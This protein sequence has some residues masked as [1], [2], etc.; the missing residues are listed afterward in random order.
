MYIDVPRPL[1]SD[2]WVFLFQKTDAGCVELTRRSGTSVFVKAFRV[3]VNKY[4]KHFFLEQH[5]TT[6]NTV[7]LQGFLLVCNLACIFRFV[8]ACNIFRIVSVSRDL[9][10]YFLSQNHHWH[11]EIRPD[12]KSEKSDLIKVKTVSILQ[13]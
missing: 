10:S 4:L 7:T 2:L 1:I 6:V 11:N 3:I 5:I 13:V 8:Q 12:E 9:R